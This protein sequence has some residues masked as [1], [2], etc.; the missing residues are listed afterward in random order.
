MMASLKRLLTR[1]FQMVPGQMRNVLTLIVGYP[2]MNQ[3]PQ[4]IILVKLIAKQQSNSFGGMKQFPK[5]ICSRDI[6]SN[7]VLNIS[8]G[9]EEVGEV[10]L[11]LLMFLI[12]AWVVTYCVIWK[13]L[14]NSGKVIQGSCKAFV[15]G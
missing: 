9:I 13:G 14:H 7:E 12:L 1:K 10:Q 15:E 5:L 3:S 8:E 6:F 4:C 2:T 11:D